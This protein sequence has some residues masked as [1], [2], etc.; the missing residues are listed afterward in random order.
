MEEIIC[1]LLA[2]NIVTFILYGIDKYKA[3]KGKWRISEATLLTMA[4]IGG[5]IGAWAGMRLWHHKTM[6]KKFKYGIPVII[7][8]QVALAVYLLTNFE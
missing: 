7:I 1:Y 5:S 2:V 6:H 4:A 8:L 3:K